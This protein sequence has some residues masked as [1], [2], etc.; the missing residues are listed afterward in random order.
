M[1]FVPTLFPQISPAIMHTSQKPAFLICW[2]KLFQLF[3]CQTQGTVPDGKTV[4]MSHKGTKD[5][6][7]VGDNSRSA[8]W[9]TGHYWFISK[10]I[11]NKAHA[12]SQVTLTHT[13]FCRVYVMFSRSLLQLQ[14]APPPRPQS[15][16]WK[17][18]VRNITAKTMSDGLVFS[19]WWGIYEYH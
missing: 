14:S 5:W 3:Y 1:H 4:E 15:L 18:Q 6:L 2:K 16:S 13:H 17:L 11:F 9:D 7:T 12:F 10:I 8:S 19:Q